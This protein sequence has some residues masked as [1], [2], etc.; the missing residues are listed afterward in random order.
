MQ[1]KTV[2][3]SATNGIYHEVRPNALPESRGSA[4]AEGMTTQLRELLRLIPV[5]E[6]IRMD[7]DGIVHLDL[8]ECASDM[9]MNAFDMVLVALIQLQ[10]H[11][12]G[13]FE[14]REL[15]SRADKDA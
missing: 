8:A 13:D 6:D 5:I 12:G 14:L 10:L 7:I 1:Q 11:N 9:R 3:S 15:M 2:I 4:W